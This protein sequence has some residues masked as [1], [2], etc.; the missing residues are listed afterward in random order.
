MGEGC[1]MKPRSKTS[2][3]REGA[4][5]PWAHCPCKPF[6]WPWRNSTTWS[7]PSGCGPSRS[8]PIS[9]GANSTIPTSLPLWKR[10]CDLGVFVLLHPPLRP[11]GL[12]RVGDYF[13]NNLISY[14]TDTTIAASRLIFAGLLDQLPDLQT[15]SGSWWRFLALPDRTPRPRLRRASRL[16]AQNC[17]RAL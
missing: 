3:R 14:P 4:S 7:P 2:A 5:R 10:L 15:V 16:Q 1:R 12:D 8:A 17:T 13:L 6:R 11:V 9:T